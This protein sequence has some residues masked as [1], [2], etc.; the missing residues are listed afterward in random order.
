MAWYKKV[1]E[2]NKKEIVSSAAFGFIFVL[3]ILLWHFAFG[4]SFE[5]T[6]ISPISAP[7][8]F[9]RIFYS[10]LVYVTFGYVLYVIGFYKL[11]AVIFG[12]ILGDWHTY[13]AIKSI[14]WTALILLTY[15]LVQK[16]V[17]L[18]NSTLSFFYNVLNFLLYLAPPLGVSLILFVIG[19]IFFKRYADRKSVRR[20]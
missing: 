14:I 17:D 15:W 20:I 16:I 11:L 19:Y 3:I 10:A 1:I 12:E 7:S 18:I 2:K 9:I 5:W 4:N 8:I 6:A 13:R